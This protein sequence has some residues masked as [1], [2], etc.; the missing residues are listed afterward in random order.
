MQASPDDIDIAALGRAVKRNGLRL[1]VAM[2]VAGAA[3]WLVLAAMAPQYRSAAQIILSRDASIYT[4]PRAELQP[5]AESLKIDQDEISSQVEVIQSADALQRIIDDLQL[6]KRPELNSALRSAGPITAVLRLIGLADGDRK[7]PERERVFNAFRK[8]LVVYPVAKSHVIAIEFTSSD[9]KLAADIANAVANAYIESNRLQQLRRDSDATDWIGSRIDELKADAETADA[10]LEKYRAQSGQLAGQ[11]NV[12]LNTQQLSELN[13]QLSTTRA[14]RS[15]AETR[16]KEVRAMLASGDIDASPDILRSPIIQRLMEQRVA[17]EREVAELSATLLAKHPR[18]LQAASK[19][20]KIK[21]ELRREALKV[22]KSLE[23]EAEIARSREAAVAASMQELT[24]KAEQSS[25]SQAKLAGLERAAKSKR[26]LYEA[27]LD[28]FNEAVTRDQRAVPAYARLIAQAQPSSIPDFP[29]KVPSTLLA[30]VGM[31]LAGLGLV[32]TRELMKGARG[33]SRRPAI[34]APVTDAVA[35]PSYIDPIRRS[36]VG[37]QRGAP[38]PEISLGA[39][40]Q[41]LNRRASTAPGQRTLLVSTG[42]PSDVPGTALKIARALAKAGR[43]V[44]IVDAGADGAGLASS[45]AIA[46]EPGLGE[47]ISG[48]ASFEEVLASDPASGVGLI[49]AGARAKASFQIEARDQLQQALDTLAES[50]EQVIVVISAARLK[51]LMGALAGVIDTAIDIG[52]GRGSSPVE[53]LLTEAG[54]E[55]MR[56]GPTAVQGQ[57]P[58]PAAPRPQP[59]A[60]E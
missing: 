18:M 2:L 15:E 29:K 53:R 39:I 17:A 33:D 30:M 9:P 21:S 37:K 32:I 28:R 49:P 47:V 38:A 36:A 22:V 7:L 59:P 48:E 34:A 51:L 26:D 40:A 43:S 54:I 16:A 44:V 13:T 52:G 20:A 56:N 60:A 3:T 46:S 55:V 8:S 45:A 24:D 19:L 14:Q 42:G 10:A 6:E 1:A 58:R 31:L 41:Q 27:Y 12:T 11:N 35:P 5:S 23:N 25:E 50:F 57:G 4:R